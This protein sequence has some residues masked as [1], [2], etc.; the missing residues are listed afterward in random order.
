MAAPPFSFL[1]NVALLA[2]FLVATAFIEDY[3]WI[4]LGVALG[5]LFAP[6]FELAYVARIEATLGTPLIEE[7]RGEVSH[8]TT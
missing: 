8:R 6:L 4:I 1:I 3:S 2:V 5:V 7:E